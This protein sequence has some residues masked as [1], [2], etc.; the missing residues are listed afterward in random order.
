MQ[1]VSHTDYQNSSDY[2]AKVRSY[3][4]HMDLYQIM[5]YVF[6]CLLLKMLALSHKMGKSV[7]KTHLISD[8]I[9]LCVCLCFL[10]IRFPYLLVGSSHG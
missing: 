6:N 7:N 10:N 3:I 4:L 2:D 1:N 8:S 9:F 5:I